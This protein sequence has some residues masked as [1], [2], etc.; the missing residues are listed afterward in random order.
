[1]V[2]ALLALAAC[3]SSTTTTTAGS[4]AAATTAGSSA[5]AT[6]S[7][8]IHITLVLGV[9]GFDYYTTLACGAQAEAKKLGVSLTTQGASTF[10]PSAQIPI[11]DALTAAHPDAAIVAPTDSQALVAP[12]ERVQNAGIKLVLVDTGVDNP[13]VGQA[14]VVSDNMAGGVAAGQTI[15]KLTGGKADV[16]IVSTA[17]GVTT[18][19]QRL[20]GLKSVFATSSGL[21]IVSTQY[22]GGNVAMAASVAE[23]ALRANP[24]IT[25]AF[26]TNLASGQGL[27]SA[28]QHMGLTGKIKVVE[29]DAGVAQALALQQGLVQALIAQQPAA[30][31]AKAVEAA[32]AILTGKP[33]T[34]SQTTG[35]TVITKDNFGVTKSAVYVSHC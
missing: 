21:K 35:V 8:P 4:S 26:A 11:V 14:Q 16:L 15:A 3:S 20:T 24:G 34:K 32:V 18:E 2:A 22:D 13:S 29:Y 5:A 12:L 6:A 33:F 27:A 28:V 25:A 19:D 9:T 1:M 17:P 31:G 30:E 10:S 23:A 7:K